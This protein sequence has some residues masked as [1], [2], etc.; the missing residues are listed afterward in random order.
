M[1]DHNFRPAIDIPGARAEFTADPTSLSKVLATF[2]G[3]AKIVAIT[4]QPDQGFGENTVELRTH[5]IHEGSIC[6]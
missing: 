1:D 5:A 2:H 3:G 6:I 4:A